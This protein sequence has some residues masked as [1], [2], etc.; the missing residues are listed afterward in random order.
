MS[1]SEDK[2]NTNVP[3]DPLLRLASF[4]PP[5]DLSLGGLKPNKKVFTPNLNVARKKQNSVT[6]S[7]SKVVKKEE[8]NKKDRKSDKNLKNGPKV[9]RSTGV[10]SE[11]L[12][13]VER[14]HH[15][16]VS[17]GRDSEPA[18]ALQK[19][20]IKMENIVKI[21]Y[22]DEEQKIREAYGEEWYEAEC[23]TF[24]DEEAPIKL[25]PNGIEDVKPVS[26]GKMFVKQTDVT[27]LLKNDK[28]TLIFLQLPD[29]LPGRGGDDDFRRKH[30]EPSTS[31]ADDN[32]QQ[33]NRCRLKDLQEGRIGTMRVH[34]SGKVTMY[35]GD[36]LYEVSTGIRP[37]FHQELVSTAVDDTSRSANLISLGDLQNKLDITPHWESIFEKMSM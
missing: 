23:E 22:D 36:T 26:I 8:K 29:I 27:E 20:T 13:S 31:E 15:S 5:R 6:P 21:D 18:Q 30:D 12:G 2:F 10:F 16:R 4:K 3:V 32:P 9:I 33:D 19:P 35:I 24:S 28:P 34:R 11:G 1:N 25:P 17:Y 37:S 14:H 7:N